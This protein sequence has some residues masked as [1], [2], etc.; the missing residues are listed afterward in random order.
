MCR[1][2][3][4]TQIINKSLRSWQ[5]SVQKNKQRILN[6]I[7][8]QA[9]FSIADSVLM[10]TVNWSKAVLASNK[11]YI[12]GHFVPMPCPAEYNFFFT[13]DLLL[14][15]LGAMNFDLDYMKHGFQFLLSLTKEDSVLAHAYYWK[16]S[17]FH[18][19]YCNADNWNNMWIIITAAA[20]LKRSA[21]HE[22]VQKLF[23]ILQKSLQL[24]LQS[25]GE[26]DLMYASRPD[27][28]DI[29]NVTG[30]K[31][32]NTTLM[33]KA[34]QD[35][36]YIAMQLNKN[37][38][39]LSEYMRTTTRTKHAFN[40]KFWDEKADFLMNMIDKKTVD[41]H[42]YSGSLVSTFFGLLDND[43]KSLVLKTAKDTLL[44]INIGIRNAMPPDFHEM[45]SV[46]KFNGM[47]AGAPYF[48]F[49]GA[50]WPQGNIWYAL[51]LISDS[52]MEEAASVVKKYLSLN[53]IKNSPNGQP[54]F[55]ECRITDPASPRYGEI[56]KPTFLWAGGWYLYTLYQLAGLRENSWN[57]YFDPNLPR[58][59]ENAEYDLSLFGKL[60]RVTWQGQGNY[61][62]QIKIDGQVHHSCIIHSPASNIILH[63][64]EPSTPYLAE[65]N[66]QIDT[67]IFQE[68][69]KIFRI[70]LSGITD[71]LAS[72][73]IV[74]PTRLKKEEINASDLFYQLEEKKS[75]NIY[76]YYLK[77]KMIRQHSELVFHF[78]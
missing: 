37:D 6:Y 69:Q 10:Q 17:R 7:F 43:K 70:T 32:Y 73:T 78:I 2:R 72:L 36:A 1:Q 42:Y 64:G 11:H 71:Q 51:G 61:F 57:M 18:T 44:D 19:E 50:V 66:C 26:D 20:Y 53:G 41:Y 25:K 58:G 52:Q 49:N 68:A 13:H 8:R 46:Y 3:E 12:N 16:D 63:R 35:F 47:E 74:S 27:W 39:P 4:G 5:K 38:E 14:T 22:T 65:A 33:Y 28:W 45:I 54:S 55:Y 59:F 60:C 40:K 62:S 24:M 76:T 29:G 67:V 15:A 77:I 75:G 31:V 34:L 23:P 21:D 56:D 30:A 9:R 48:Y